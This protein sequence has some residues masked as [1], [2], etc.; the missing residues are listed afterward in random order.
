MPF[1]R[2]CGREEVRGLA[3]RGRERRG[4]QVKLTLALL[5]EV[6]VEEDE[7]ARVS[8]ELLLDS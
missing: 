4:G 7:D 2:L 1:N 3:F 6:Q 5:L 8:S